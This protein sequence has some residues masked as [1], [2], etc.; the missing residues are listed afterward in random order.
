MECLFLLSDI[1][2]I[3][4]LQTLFHS[5]NMFQPSSQKKTVLQKKVNRIIFFKNK[6]II[7]NKQQT[8][9][10]KMA[11]LANVKPIFAR[12]LKYLIEGLAVALAAYYIPRKKID[13]HEVITIA[14]AAAAVFAV[15]DVLAPAIGD[16]TRTGMGLGIGLLAVL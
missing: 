16:S 10:K 9:H 12:A 6:K 8:Q 11:S 5:E 2:E 15:L 14:I 7:S 13:I 1:Q 4:S 3:V